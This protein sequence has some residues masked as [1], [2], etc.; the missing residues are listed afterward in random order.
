MMNEQ[1]RTA[2]RTD[3]ERLYPGW[4]SKITGRHRV[5]RQEREAYIQGRL[6]QAAQPAQDEHHTM[7]ELYDYRMVYHAHAAHGW[8]ATGVPVV[9]SWKHSDGEFCFDGGWFI[10]VATLP[11]GQVSNHY[12][13]EYWDLF[14]V[15][16]A[17]L[18]PEYDGHT[19]Q[20]ALKRL[21]DALV[22]G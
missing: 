8:L 21:R 12:S 2:A 18:P 13:A 16:V 17:E 10:V 1:I 5:H 7:D 9:K 15:P 11:T 22:S 4:L 14:A 6:D 3:A 20:D 19:P